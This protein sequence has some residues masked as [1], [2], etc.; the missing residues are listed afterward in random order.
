MKLNNELP[1][2]TEEEA[3]KTW[4]EHYQRIKKQTLS[5]SYDSLVRNGK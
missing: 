5:V 2:M 1:I 4:D 3:Q